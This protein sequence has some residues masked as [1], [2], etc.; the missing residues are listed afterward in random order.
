M[1]IFTAESSKGVIESA[2]ALVAVVVSL[3]V[4]IAVLGIYDEQHE[5]FVLVVSH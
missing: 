3:N 4:V 1:R 5:V 2:Q